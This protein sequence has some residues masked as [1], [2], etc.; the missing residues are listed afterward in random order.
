MATDLEQLI[1]ELVA[2]WDPT[3]DLSG[4]STF[5]TRVLAPLLKRLG[6]DPLAMDL[7]A[8]YEALMLERLPGV[9]VSPLSAFRNLLMQALAVLSEPLRR[10]VQ[11]TR[12]TKSLLNAESMT[13]DEVN[14]LLANFF[15]ELREGTTATGIVRMYFT[16][17]QSV[18]VSA[19]TQFLTG[20]NLAF[21]PA[22]VQSI[23]AIQ[24]S[25]QQEGSLFYF[26]VNVQAESTGPAYSVARDSIT[27]VL[28]VLGAVRVRN[29][30]RMSTAFADESKLDGVARAQQ[31]ITTRNLITAP[32]IAY[33]LPNAFGWITSPSVVGAGDPEM[34]RDVIR[35]PVSIS[36]IPGGLTGRVSPDLPLGQE[37]HIGGKTDIY[38]APTL[39]Q[40]DE[41]DIENVTD[42]GLR[43]HAAATGFT[44]SGG[45]TFSFRDDFGFFVLRGVTAG[46]IL[47]LGALELEVTSVV[48]EV[49]LLVATEI[50]GGIF[51]SPYE[52][53][54]RVP[55]QITVPLFDLVAEVNGIPVLTPAGLPVAP[56]P[57]T[58]D[59]VPSTVKVTNVAGRNAPLP[60]VRIK[61]VEFLDP[62]TQ[63]PLGQ[64]L[65]MRDCIHVDTPLGL[66]GGTSV[67]PSKGKVRFYFRNAVNVYV[68]RSST[69]VSHQGRNYRPAL[70]FAGN[71]LGVP[72]PSERK[73]TLLGDVTA[74]I[75]VGDR[76]GATSGLLAGMNLCVLGLEF[77]GVLTEVDVREDL[78]WLPDP[79]D[80]TTSFAARR[81]I[82]QS[83]M[84]LDPVSGVYFVDFDFEDFVVG[85]LG[86]RPAGTE[87]EVNLVTSEGWSLRP[88]HDVESFSVREK[89]V[90]QVS[91]YVNDTTL[92]SEEFTAPALRLVLVTS[93]DIPPVQAFADSPGQRIVSE[94]TLI[95]QSLPILVSC[96]PVTRGITTALA[97]ELLSNY[98]EALP[99]SGTLEVS[100]LSDVVYAKGATYFKHPL[101]LVGLG[102]RP[103]RSWFLL[104]SEDALTSIKTQKFIPEVIEPTLG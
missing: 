74:Q 85:V 58:L 43:V 64:P 17:P 22:S 82:L 78:S 99:E 35:G 94:D 55:G 61:Q 24:M 90:F 76:L 97:K 14:A 4:G 87:F 62:L 81:G 3:I 28:G 56:Y 12:I 29:P 63:Q 42:K 77:T 20:T 83:N 103:D 59:P 67:L 96:S 84:T 60:L 54:R 68:S 40:E 31:G 8:F 52:I 51:K 49:E 5:R 93:P 11:S 30:A 80:N 79:V 1:L 38:L 48:S 26:D 27:R 101:L 6:P 86:D 25:F 95:R 21:L 15:T 65:P 104:R 36:G 19:G 18:T 46:D 44:V 88:L 71:T 69:V 73:V 102:Q 98:I 70:E 91:D 50:P 9:D 23:S 13:R 32:G 45:P 47:R 100:D 34:R 66:L 16:A 10:E 75:A 2:S 41:L 57:G 37:V 92:I 33:V 53:V 7:E 39:R 89:L 72:D